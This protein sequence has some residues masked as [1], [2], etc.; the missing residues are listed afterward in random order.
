MNLRQLKK[1]DKR[2][3]AILLALHRGAVS[4]SGF[5]LNDDGRYSYEWR[6]S[7]EYDE[8]DEQP[9]LDY[10]ND[11]EG[12]A[13][14][15]DCIDPKTGDYLPDD[16]C[17]PYPPSAMRKLPA[18]WRWRGGKVVPVDKHGAMVRQKVKP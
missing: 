3:A 11:I 2:A 5:G 9:A 18:G 13:Y 8:W 12:L 15:A 17:P 6:C 10:L 16:Q 1:Q 4:P 14:M 7:Y